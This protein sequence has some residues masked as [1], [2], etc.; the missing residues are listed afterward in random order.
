MRNWLRNDYDEQVDAISDSKKLVVDVINTNSDPGVV[1]RTTNIISATHAT[2]GMSTQKLLINPTIQVVV[3]PITLLFTYGVV[4]MR[5]SLSPRQTVLPQENVTDAARSYARIY[6]TPGKLSGAERD[7]ATPRDASSSETNSRFI[8]Q[9]PGF[10][11][12]SVS[13]A[14]FRDQYIFNP[15]HPSSILKGTRV[16]SH[17]TVVLMNLR[18]KI[19]TLQ[20]S[21]VM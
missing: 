20:A 14:Q 19:V 17:L 15:R 5:E 16:S 11:V 18:P 8:F 1:T 13:P 3:G 12:T 6:R 9:I 10:L 21:S 7:G 4:G 2:N